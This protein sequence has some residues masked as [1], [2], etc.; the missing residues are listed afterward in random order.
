MQREGKGALERQEV[1]EIAQVRN[2]Q[3]LNLSDSYD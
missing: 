1:S 3:V 2:D